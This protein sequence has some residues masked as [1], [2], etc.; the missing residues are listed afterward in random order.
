M[1][2]R[3]VLF[4]EFVTGLKQDIARE[5]TAREMFLAEMNVLKTKLKGVDI[6]ESA[7]DKDALITEGLEQAFKNFMKISRKGLAKTIGL[8]VGLNLLS[9]GLPQDAVASAAQNAGMNKNQIEQV[10]SAY[11]DAAGEKQKTGSVQ[12]VQGDTISYTVPVS[13]LNVADRKQ[14]A[15]LISNPS[16]EQIES[17]KKN[18]YNN[19][20]FSMVFTGDEA[21][22]E[23]I[24]KYSYFIYKEGSKSWDTYWNALENASIDEPFFTANGLVYVNAKHNAKITPDPIPDPTPAE[25]EPVMVKEV[26]PTRMMDYSGIVAQGVELYKYLAKGTNKVTTSRFGDTER[27]FTNMKEFVAAFAK[28]N[29]K[30]LKEYSEQEITDL[31]SKGLKHEIPVSKLK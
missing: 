19:P 31:L 2:K 9:A 14:A 6:N 20:A 7:V 28:Y 5:S 10:V 27:T 29:G 13:R 25:A 30:G 3:P 21:D 15:V 4:N 16:K 23:G 24:G 8:A 26:E 12:T 11:K 1:I 22:I 18:L 17:A